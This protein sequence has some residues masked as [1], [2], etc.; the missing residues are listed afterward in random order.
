MEQYILELIRNNNRVIIPNFGAFIVAKEKGFT[1][2]FNNFLSFNDG[3]LVEHVMNKEDVDKLE[4]TDRV[5]K[6]VERINKTLDTT[7]NYQLEGLGV[8]NKDS[9]GILRFTQ[10]EELNKTFFDSPEEIKDS[11]E[12]LDIESATTEDDT[13]GQPE[14]PAVVVPPVA[15][16]VVETP[17][18]EPEK[19]YTK[20]TI[21]KDSQ[22]EKKKKE[23]I[24]LFI[25]LFIL[26][27][28]IGFGIYYFFFTDINE[29][30]PV[31]AKQEI[32]KKK[33]ILKPENKSVDDGIVAG[34]ESTVEK[35][36]VK[37]EKVT[38][39]AVK[40]TTITSRRHYII[41]GS[42]KEER[43]AKKYVEMMRR[44]GFT[45]PVTIPRGGMYLVGIDSFSSL[46]KAMKRQEEMLTQYKLE[47]W[48]L[49]VK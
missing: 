26:I 4:A 24:V 6:F 16:D 45:S 12:L 10:D 7:G 40:K 30:T 18:S 42:F 48:I 1:I 41:T 38:T 36:S 17:V 35:K 11:D 49:T 47:S 37:E 31:K 27:P 25:V 5:N 19:T 13:T 15:N 29:A 3:L 34:P 20:K 33:P 2:L 22:K 21:H 28:I 44:K 8:F 32:V 46:T 43:N 9:S 14:E 39:P 23:T